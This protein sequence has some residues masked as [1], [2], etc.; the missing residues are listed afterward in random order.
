[1]PL[2]DLRDRLLGLALEQVGEGLALDAARVARVAVDHLPLGLVGGEH[3]LGGVD[4]DHVVAGVEVR[5]EDRLVL[6]PQDPGDLGGH[7]AEH[8]ALGVDDVPGCARSRRL[9]G[10][11]WARDE[12]W[13]FR[14]GGGRAADAEAGRGDGPA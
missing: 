3:D 12:S 1:M 11:R 9:W 5:G 2:I 7:A 8:H 14:L 6:A 13:D 10:C 4:D